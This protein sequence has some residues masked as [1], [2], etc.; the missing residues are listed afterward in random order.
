MEARLKVTQ[1]ENEMLRNQLDVQL[2]VNQLQQQ[3]IVA[4]SVSL[5]MEKKHQAKY[6]SAPQPQ[7]PTSQ[8]QYP[9]QSD[10]DLPPY[11]Q[12]PATLSAPALTP[13]NKGKDEAGGVT[14]GGFQI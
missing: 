12:H 8:P 7:R 10:P 4:S 14:N 3:E 5:E 2:S 13:Q 9:A 11:P 1:K 6:P